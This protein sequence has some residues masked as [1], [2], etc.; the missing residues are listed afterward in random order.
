MREGEIG[1]EEIITNNSLSFVMN[2]LKKIQDAMRGLGELPGEGIL[3]AE[4]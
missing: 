2:T 3:Q 1:I 4:T